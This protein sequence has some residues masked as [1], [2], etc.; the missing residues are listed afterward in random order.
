M[1]VLEALVLRG[2]ITFGMSERI[3]NGKNND[4]PIDRS[5][6]NGRFVVSFTHT[7]E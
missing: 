7:P 3:A 6:T 5:R 2:T 1:Q 4:Q